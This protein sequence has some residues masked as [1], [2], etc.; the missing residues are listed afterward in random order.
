M[1]NLYGGAM[2]EYL[3]YGGFEWLKNVDEIDVNSVNK[4][5]E[6]GYFLEVDL[7]CLDELPELYN[8]YPLAPDYQN[9]VKKLQINME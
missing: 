5:S 1:K 3:P 7:E 2:G 9:T 8:D 4:K 6:R